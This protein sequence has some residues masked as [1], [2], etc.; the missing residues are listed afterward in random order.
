MNSVESIQSTVFLKP[1]SED[2]HT[3]VDS[4]D[5]LVAFAPVP[6]SDGRR[7]DWQ[8]FRKASC[9]VTEQQTGHP[10]RSL[11]RTQQIPDN[12]LI[13][14]GSSRSFY[15]CRQSVQPE[16]RQLCSEGFD[17]VHP[18]HPFISDQISMVK[19]EMKP[20]PSP[21]YP[22]GLEMSRHPTSSISMA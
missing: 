16:V 8:S 6:I 13:S 18:S 5:D 21:G 14:D 4:D 9:V 22:R 7:A 19:S 11:Q 3:A 17:P 20:V 2:V 15:D 10:W 1:M 12:V